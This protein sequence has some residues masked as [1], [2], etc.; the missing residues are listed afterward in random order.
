MMLYDARA[1][2]MIDGEAPTG[3]KGFMSFPRLLQILDKAG[4]IGPGEIV[5]HIEISDRGFTFRYEQ[6]PAKGKSS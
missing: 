3:V 2:K 6:K 5:T 4:E 1:W